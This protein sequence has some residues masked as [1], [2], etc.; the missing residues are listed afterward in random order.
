MITPANNTTSTS[1]PNR[2]SAEQRARY[3]M[4]H[5]KE[6]LASIN[7]SVVR[8]ADAIREER[9]EDAINAAPSISMFDRRMDSLCK[10]LR[11]VSPDEFVAIWYDE[12]DFDAGHGPS[13]ILGPVQPSIAKKTYDKAAHPDTGGWAVIANRDSWSKG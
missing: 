11:E 9:W 10:T 3:H 5:I 8:M 2:P 1:N 6:R 12:N 4:E 7:T 13:A